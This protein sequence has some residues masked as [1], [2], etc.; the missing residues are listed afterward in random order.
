L[1]NDGRGCQRQVLCRFVLD[2]ERK[3]ESLGPES[4]RDSLEEWD[5]IKHMYVML[6]LEEE[7]SIEFTDD[8]IANL[9]SISDLMHAMTA[10]TG[11]T[12]SWL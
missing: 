6:A 3:A 12:L 11:A 7:F 10:K 9:A 2:I 8:E 4:S 5:S 1:T